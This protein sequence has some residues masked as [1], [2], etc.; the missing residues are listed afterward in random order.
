MVK[1]GVNQIWPEEDLR[2]RTLLETPISDLTME[3]LIFLTKMSDFLTS[4]HMLSRYNVPEKIELD[5]VP[6]YRQLAD[7]IRT[8]FGEVVSIETGFSYQLDP[9]KIV[10][11]TDAETED[12]ILEFKTSKYDSQSADLLQVW[13]YHLFTSSESLPD[14]AGKKTPVLINLETGTYGTVQSTRDEIQWFYILRAYFE[15]RTRYMAVQT[16]LSRLLDQNIIQPNGTSIPFQVPDFR[17]NDYLVDTEYC[18]NNRFIPEIFEIAAVNVRNPYRSLIQTVQINGTGIVKFATNWL[19]VHPE[20]FATSLTLPEIQT[21]FTK[22]TGL[23]DVPIRFFNFCSPVDTRWCT[24]DHVKIDLRTSIAKEC[25]KTGFF[26]TGKGSVPKLTDCYGT[27]G[28]DPNLVTLRPHT[29]LSDALILY[30][31]VWLRSLSL[32]T[33]SGCAASV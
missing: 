11:I 5:L 7:E 27:I 8:L 26:I 6:T 17:E 21:L 22:I 23:Y 18:N 29:A 24:I 25:K 1:D 19:K 3:D 15:I 12:R 31:L 33:W 32:E 14:L 30:E 2:F 20:Q 28:L 9:E 16:Q 13:L 4:G 10:G